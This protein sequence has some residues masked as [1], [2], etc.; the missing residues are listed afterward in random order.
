MGK[1]GGLGGAVEF[2]CHAGSSCAGE[3]A[4]QGGILQQSFDGA[5]EGG[6]I[7]RGHEQA[8]FAGTDQ[9]GDAGDLGGDH[10]NLGRQRLHQDDGQAFGEGWQDQGIGF[11]EKRGNIGLRAVA[12]EFDPAG[13]TELLRLRFEPGTVGA[14][15]DE[16]EIERCLSELDQG[17]EEN[18]KA[19]DGGK[20]A[21]EEELRGGV[22][23]RSVRR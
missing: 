19:F 14:V 9:F 16:D 23:G 13:K 12:E 20:T 18:G 6:G 8:G 10:G 2:G 15:A 7:A 1:A 17:V 22:F 11:L 4:R 5:G 21:D 3:A